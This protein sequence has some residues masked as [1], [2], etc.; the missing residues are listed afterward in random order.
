MGFLVRTGGNV[1]STL[2]EL[3]SVS[4]GKSMSIVKKKQLIKAQIALRREEQHHIE[5][6]KRAVNF[7][8][9]DIDNDVTWFPFDDSIVEASIPQSRGAVF[10][11]DSHID[12]LSDS[13]S[14]SESSDDNMPPG[15][16]FVDK[17][18]DD[19]DEDQIKADADE[20]KS[21]SLASLQCSFSN[22]LMREVAYK[23]LPF[24]YRC[25]L[26]RHIATWFETTY[27]KQLAPYTQTL[28]HH[29]QVVAECE[30]DAVLKTVAR[31]KAIMYL[32][33]S[34]QVLFDFSCLI[35][36]NGLLNFQFFS[37]VVVSEPTPRLFSCSSKR[38]SNSTNY[39][40]RLSTNCH[41]DAPA[42]PFSLLMRSLLGRTCWT[43]SLRCSWI[44]LWIQSPCFGRA[45]N[46]RPCSWLLCC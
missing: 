5:M 22:V 44:I 26:H 7:T 35:F 28:A 36:F 23:R 24:R 11:L 33:R 20:V 3:R 27:A 9:S 14:E 38:S 16:K 39:R 19:S 40:C 29:W 15:F 6:K 46:N 45:L 42:R 34:A 1:H 4:G 31:R 32:Q 2:R 18:H 25:E 41:I 43:R 30:N 10:Q 37:G 13:D 12:L 17:R 21:S 8:Q